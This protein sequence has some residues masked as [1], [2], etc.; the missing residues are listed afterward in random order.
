M[1]LVAPFLVMLIFAIAQFG[2]YFSQR[3]DTTNAARDAARRLAL[4]LPPRYPDGIT[5]VSTSVNC[6]GGDAVVEVTSSYSFSIP[7]ITIVTSDIK[8]KGAMRCGG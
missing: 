5:P 4:G 2:M 3:I 8:A 7:F 1:V 6:P